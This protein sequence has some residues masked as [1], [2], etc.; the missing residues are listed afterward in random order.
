MAFSVTYTSKHKDVG[1]RSEFEK[2]CSAAAGRTPYMD[3]FQMGCPTHA[4]IRYTSHT[5][6][7]AN[8]DVQ[9]LYLPSKNFI[10]IECSSFTF[11]IRAEL[12]ISVNN[13][14]KHIHIKSVNCTCHNTWPISDGFCFGGDEL[15]REAIEYCN[16]R[17][18]HILDQMAL[19]FF[20][21]GWEFASPSNCIS[22]LK[23]ADIIY[24]KQWVSKL[25]GFRNLWDKTIAYFD[26]EQD[27]AATKIQ[28]AFR[29][30]KVRMK[31][32]YNPYNRLGKYV[33]MKAGGFWSI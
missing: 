26:L 20:G 31:Y 2:Y 21:V 3:W 17:D 16:I 10:E 11:H 9:Y 14:D 33:T 8:H 32:R 15:F 30:W 1:E 12:G 6:E 18:I 28:A 22:Y 4:A 19:E 13:V 29:G 27:A 5:G 23:D 25:G 7:F 24:L